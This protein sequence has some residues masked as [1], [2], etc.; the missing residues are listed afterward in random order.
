MDNRELLQEPK[1]YGDCTDIFQ[2][3]GLAMPVNL[4]Y[5]FE[6][7]GMLVKL[8]NEMTKIEQQNEILKKALEWYAEAWGNA[9]IG[10]KARKALVANLSLEVKNG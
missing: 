4:D 7:A 5:R 3:F 8:H 1:T 9:D 2:K 10:D 6:N